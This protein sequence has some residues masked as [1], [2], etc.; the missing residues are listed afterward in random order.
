[1]SE[2][3]E[4]GARNGDRSWRLLGF[5]AVGTMAPVG[6]VAAGAARPAPGLI[7]AAL[8]AAV[9]LAM[10]LRGRAASA[11][12]AESPDGRPLDGGPFAAML[13]Q[14]A[15]PILLIAGGEREDSSTRRFLFANG[16]AR[17]LLRI[18]RPGGPLT[19]AIRAP[20]VL[21][22]VDEA[23]YERAPAH[24]VYEL[25]GVQ[26]RFWQ[27][28]ALPL[29]ESAGPRMAVLWLRD[30]TELRRSERAR[31]DFLANASHEL[32]TPLASLAGFIE[33]L[34]GHARDDV[35]ARERF[36][37]IMQSQAERMRRLID[38]LMSLSRIELGEHIPPSGVVDL[39]ALVSDVVD[40]LAPLAAERCVRIETGAATAHPVL[41]LA[42]RDQILQVI[43]NLV[44][45]AV[46]YTPLGGRV[47]IAVQADL[48]LSAAATPTAG[49]SSHFSLL[50][51]DHAA[52]RAYVA[53]RVRDFGAGI[54]RNHLPR[55]TERFYRVEGQKARERPGTGLG[56][57][58]VKHIVN[59]HRGGLLVE[60][61]PGEGSA[62]T[63]YFP[64][65][66]AEAAA[67][68]ETAGLTA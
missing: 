57:A 29:A 62:F 36:L 60:S 56:L 41:A 17:S 14:I 7:A 55:L 24:A 18:Q 3:P 44:E 16:A 45:N 4:R 32:R 1:M 23:L 63:A 13:E 27:A 31:A 59:R 65:I 67:D 22:A 10:A 42:D 21:D 61:G 38:D 2:T 33:T 12:R 8:V 39:G 64:M 43:Q 68:A 50:T 15:D 9:G 53:V 26:D 20:E 40:A 58:I 28:R 37:A 35:A 5:A 25:R 47:S 11:D 54:A 51:P 19:T 6:L 48:A 30:E 46:K 49:L 52:G 66:P 34:R